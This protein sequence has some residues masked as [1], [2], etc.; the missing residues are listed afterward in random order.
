M[1]VEMDAAVREYVT[2]VLA[3]ILYG[4]QASVKLD[5]KNS[6]LQERAVM[7]VLEGM[8]RAVIRRA[9]GAGDRRALGKANLARRARASLRLAGKDFLASRSPLAQ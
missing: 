7:C 2:R 1:K 5:E 3:S 4:P 8:V 9:S 6:R